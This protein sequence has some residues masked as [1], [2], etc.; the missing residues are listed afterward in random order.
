MERYYEVLRKNELFKDAGAEELR[1][2]LACLGYTVRQY[3]KNDM[4]WNVGA[5]ARSFGIV[6]AEMCIRDSART[7][8]S[9]CI[10]LHLS[11]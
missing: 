7:V 3:P 2:M 4:I 11:E 9:R 1:S 10:F 6:L 8:R 5:D